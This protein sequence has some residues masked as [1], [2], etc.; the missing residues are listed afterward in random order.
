[1][2]RK[3]TLLLFFSIS[4]LT[5]R[6]Q[7]EMS[8]SQCVQYALENHTQIRIAELD[9][10]DAEW[11]IKE[12]TA[13]AYPN[14][15][16]GAHYNYFLQQPAIPSEALGFGS[17]GESIRFALKKDMGAS[18]SATQLIFNNSLLATIKAAKM[19]K[20][21]AAIQYGGVE[22]KLRNQVTD[23]YIPA[24]V[25][26]E[27]IS[28]LQKNIDNQ[29]KLVSDTKA[30]YKAGF[31]EQLDVDR[32]E[33][34]LSAFETDLESLARQRDKAIEYLKFVINMPTGD[35]LILTDDLNVLL[36]QYD[37][38][39]PKE[40]VDYMNRPD[41]VAALKAREL[42][43]IQT[44][45]YSKYWWPVINAF[46]SYDPGYQGND[47]LFWIPSSIVGVQLSMPIFD[48]G[49]ARALKERSMIQT[50][51]VDQQKRILSMSYDLA[52]ETAR[53]DYFSTKQKLADKE[54]NLTLAEKIFS[55]SETKFKE[56][57][58]SSFEV[59]QAQ[60]GLYQSQADHVN[61]RF[62]FL[63]SLVAFKQALGKNTF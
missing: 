19:Y 2:N 11:Q 25:V 14:I 59:T 27:G 62:D 20:E 32:L 46:I 44:D 60:L 40:T 63:K 43:D 58:G 16:L 61:A 9:I 51:K 24:L 42:S 18:I 5:L 1:M 7:G 39:D 13:V 48:G 17:P 21:Y 50:L 29:R 53:N 26:A 57:V 38:I 22:E 49:Y 8:L 33:F 3:C 35:T 23:A 30:N 4:F 37:D 15:S 10:Q 12:N 6:G 47:E 55:T 31:V 28:V 45:A 41:Y 52:V 56:G 36:Q 34:S 54:R